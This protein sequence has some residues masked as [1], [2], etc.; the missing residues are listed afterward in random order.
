[1]LR[2]SGAFHARV[3]TALSMFRELCHNCEQS[4]H[5][6]DAIVD[7]HW[8]SWSIE[9]AYCYCPNCKEK[10]IGLTPQRLQAAQIFS[11]TLFIGILLFLA[12]GLAAFSSNKPELVLMIGLSAFGTYLA[13]TSTL[14]DHRIIGWLLIGLSCGIYALIK[15]NT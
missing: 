10:L 5:L 11:P 1:M 15:Y 8:D 7:E 3:F 6:S 4:F 13:K 2:R 12:L 14:K 9:P